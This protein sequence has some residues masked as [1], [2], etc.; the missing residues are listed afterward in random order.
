MLPSR[1][2]GIGIE[3]W[4]HWNDAV[5]LVRHAVTCMTFNEEAVAV[6]D[7]YYDRIDVAEGDVLCASGESLNAIYLI[8]SGEVELV[9][10]RRRQVLGAGQ[11]FG[12]LGFG[13]SAESPWTARALTC[14]TL[15]RIDGASLERRLQ[16][17]RGYQPLQLQGI[18]GWDDRLIFEG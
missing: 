15:L 16:R 5:G 18:T 17:R 3:R 8:R 2:C 7:R 12:E 11:V 13:R 14:A 6:T 4:T 1:T 10:Q 9:G